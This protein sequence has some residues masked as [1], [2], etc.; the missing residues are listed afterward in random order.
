MKYLI[1]IIKKKTKNLEW[2]LF[3]AA[4]AEITWSQT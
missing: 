3:A 1:M 2:R 4:A